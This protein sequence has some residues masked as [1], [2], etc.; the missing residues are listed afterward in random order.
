[1]RSAAR[2]SLAHAAASVVACCLLACNERPAAVDAAPTQAP[3]AQRPSQG[4]V[5]K[6]VIAALQAAGAACKTAHPELAGR[7][8]YMPKATLSTDRSGLLTMAVEPGAQ[9]V[10][11][12]CLVEQIRASKTT[13]LA[14]ISNLVV[15]MGFSL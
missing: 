3:V 8:M 7:G 4:G 5:P 10:F 13:L 9:P 2:R 11:D 1:M 14:P 15:P 12:T 6:Q